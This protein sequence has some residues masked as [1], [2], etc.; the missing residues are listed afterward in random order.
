MRPTS[1]AAK[2]NR[3]TV[4]PGHTPSWWAAKGRQQSA[5]SLLLGLAKF[6]EHVGHD[7]LWPV[8]QRDFWLVG[9]LH[10]KAGA[11]LRPTSAPLFLSGP[12]GPIFQVAVGPQQP[13]NSRWQPFWKQWQ[14]ASRPT[15]SGMW[16]TTAGVFPVHT[17]AS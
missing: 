12:L 9:A 5:A 14:H 7:F 10:T 16:S 8:F 6:Y 1:G 17:D 15:D 4:P 3:A 11:S 2:A 13:P